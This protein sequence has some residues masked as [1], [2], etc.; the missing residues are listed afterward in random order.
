MGPVSIQRAE[1]L[2]SCDCGSALPSGPTATP[3][4]LAKPGMVAKLSVDYS[5]GKLLRRR[6][7]WLF[8]LSLDMAFKRRSNMCQRQQNETIKQ[9]DRFRRMLRWDL[10]QLRH[11]RRPSLAGA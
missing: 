5:R 1:D 8:R 9:L 3:F 11:K 2:K 7:Q 6:D 4:I 10:T